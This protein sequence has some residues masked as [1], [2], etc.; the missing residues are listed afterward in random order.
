MEKEG[1]LCEVR[2]PLA[3]YWGLSLFPQNRSSSSSSSTVTA[4]SPLKPYDLNQDLDSIHNYLRSMALQNPAMHE[5]KLK[6]VIS[7]NSGLF[8][9]EILGDPACDEEND[10]VADGEAVEIPRKRR[11]A[12]DLKR[13]RFSLKPTKSQ[14]V[15]SLIPS[16]DLDKLKDPVEFF[17]AHE[18]QENAKREIQKQTGELLESNRSDTTTKLRQRRPGLSGNNERRVRYKH[19]YPKETFDNNHYVLPTQEASESVYHGPVDES[20]DED[21]A[22]LTP[23]ENEVTNSSAI[24][25]NKINEIL[26]GLL[27]CNSEDLEGDDAVTLLQERLH[28]KPIVLEKLSVLNFPN[29]N[30]VI[31]MKSLH[32][33][34][35]NP[36]K[37]KPLSNLDNLLKGFNSRTPIRKDTGSLLQQSA[38]P[39]PPKSPFSLLSSLQR[40]LSHSKPSMDPFAA[41]GID[42]LSTRNNS[43]IRQ[44]NQELKLASGKPLNEHSASIIDDGIGT[45]KTNSV[46]DTVRNGSRSSGKSKADSSG[47]APTQLNAPLIEDIIATSETNTVENTVRDCA[48]T[49]QKSA[50]DNPRQPE[51]D[52]NIESNGPRVDMDVNIGDSGMEDSVRDC[53]STPQKSVED[54]PRQPEFDANVESNDPHID[55]DADI[56]DTGIID[57]VG[58]PNIETNGP[59]GIE[60][61]AENV[62]EH[63]AAL[64]SDDSNINLVNRPDQSDPA[65]FQ[66]N[67]R[68]KDSGRSDDGPEQCL[69]EK[70]NDNSNLP[71]SGQRRIGRPKGQRKE[72]SLS[73][74]QSLAAS[75]TSWE[76]GVRRSTR[77][78]T[79]P[80]EF[81][82]GERMVYGR[83]HNSLATVIGIKCISPGSDGKPTMK[84]KSYVSDEHKELLELASLY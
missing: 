84:V 28:I 4:S 50:E 15:E 74:R 72:K 81:W 26:N 43:P 67:D 78:R 31:D 27:Q 24:E 41:D 42:H 9:S 71:H 70:T 60:D 63:A 32:G 82:R 73:R 30:Q 44:I 21:G 46:G 33:N 51:S 40:H 25:E 8:D 57:R 54:N 34:S 62:Q 39:T 55:L 66:A 49:P 22:C 19:R 61:E 1:S 38:S 5:D 75:G 11:P 6:A 20:A 65:G 79:R 80:L 16:L 13:A 47:M 7:E 37:R 58:R 36:R 56:G 77:I 17:L 45:S 52:A 29:N 53:A 35:S 2:D 69:Q 12:L 14:S 48:S 18:R 23:L 59:Y 3:N 64:P 68:D 76:A 83:I 10:I